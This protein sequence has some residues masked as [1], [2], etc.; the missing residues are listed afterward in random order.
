VAFHLLEAARFQTTLGMFQVSLD[1]S[2]ERD[3]RASLG[4]CFLCMGIRSQLHACKRLSCCLA[5]RIEGD[6]IDAPDRFPA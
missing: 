2:L 4:R 5:R 6:G 1:D 3:P